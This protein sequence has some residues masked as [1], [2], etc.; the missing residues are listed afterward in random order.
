MESEKLPIDQVFRTVQLPSSGYSQELNPLSLH[1]E[2]AAPRQ[3]FRVWKYAV[4][5]DYKIVDAIRESCTIELLS[6]FILLAL[7][8]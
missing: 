4:K 6:C 8:A 2:T 7:S 1:R 3:V 5:D